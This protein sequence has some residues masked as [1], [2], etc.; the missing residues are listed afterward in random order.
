MTFM[1]YIRGITFSLMA[2]F[3]MTSQSAVMFAEEPTQGEIVVEKGTRETTTSSSSIDRVDSS[4]RPI[5]KTGRLPQTGELMKP[6]LLI[7]GGIF[8][9]VSILGIFVLRRTKESEE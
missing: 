1:N 3:V 6:V 2:L 5:V 4:S 8:I 9:L 7:L